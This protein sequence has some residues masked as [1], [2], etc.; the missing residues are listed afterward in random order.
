VTTPGSLSSR[1][2]AAGSAFLLDSCVYLDAM[3]GRLPDAVE[4]S[5]VTCIANHSALCLGELTQLFGR[6]DP[7]HPTTPSVLA[8]IAGTLSDIP[9]HRVAR[10]SRRAF[11]EAGMP[12]GLIDRVTHEA[13][14]NGARFNDCI[15]YLQA[16]ENGWTLLTR[17]IRDF[18]L[19]DQ[20]LPASRLLFYRQS[21]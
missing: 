16:I 17:N 6:L 12:A 4:R 18:D 13:Q 10:P 3:R 5:L 1:S 21:A 20:L 15:L 9:A 2:P 7:S 8:E 19:L 14:D 11:G